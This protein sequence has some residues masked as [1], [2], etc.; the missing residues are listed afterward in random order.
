[1]VWT[2]CKFLIKTLMP[3]ISV[4][5]IVSL[6]C[7]VVYAR[8]SLKIAIDPGHGGYEPGVVYKGVIEKKI[9][10]DISKKVE[11]FLGQVGSNVVMTRKVD[12]ALFEFSR[13]KDTLKRRDLDARVKIINHSNA[14]FFASI[15]VNSQI[16]NKNC[17]GSIVYY[18]EKSLKSKELAESI[19]DSLNRMTINN[20]KRQ[21]HKPQPADFYILKK[22]KMPGVLIETAFITNNNERYLLKKEKFQNELAYAISEGIKN[23]ELYKGSI[24]NSKPS[25]RAVKKS[26]KNTSEKL[27]CIRRK[28][29]G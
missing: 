29:Q 24:I 3:I 1:M 26:F 28:K 23:S 2:R 16:N 13:K 6:H 27:A 21:Q 10:L 22:T 15:H 4:L 25:I 14:E 20:H 11:N 9:S 18:Y 17:T 8:Q 5:I 12:T 19:Q 7:M